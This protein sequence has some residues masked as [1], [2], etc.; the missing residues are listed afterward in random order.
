MFGLDSITMG[1][2]SLH[3][4]IK[5]TYLKNVTSQAQVKR[6]MTIMSNSQQL[7]TE[8]IPSEEANLAGGCGGYQNRGP[9]P[10]DR[11]EVNVEAVAT[12][13]I[14]GLERAPSSSTVNTYTDV[15]INNRGIFA[16]A[17]SFI[18]ILF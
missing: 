1:V 8:I 14:F 11:V 15:L 4:N 16:R 2:S 17:V 5:R 10:R 6:G 12:V 3:K 9:G 18:R 7:F 13:D